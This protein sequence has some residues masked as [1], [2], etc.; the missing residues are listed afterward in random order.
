MRTFNPRVEQAAEDER[1]GKDLRVHVL[2][3]E[4]GDD[5]EVLVTNAAPVK[6]HRAKKVRC[7]FVP[8]TTQSWLLN[9]MGWS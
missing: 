6:C 7:L 2:K 1:A 9:K 8:A 5:G 4:V 3:E